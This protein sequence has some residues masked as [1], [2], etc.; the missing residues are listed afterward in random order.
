MEVQGVSSFSSRMAEIRASFGAP[1]GGAAGVAELG[2]G[3][4]NG[5][6]DVAFDAFGAAYQEALLQKASGAYAPAAGRSASVGGAGNWSWAN[7][8]GTYGDVPGAGRI[9]G[10]GGLEVP[11]ALA[12]YGNGH[13]PYEAL[14]PIG[15]GGHRLYQPAAESFVAMRAAAAQDGV[16]LT[17]TDSYRTYDQQVE[18]AQ[19]KGLYENGGLAA[20]PGTSPHGWGMAV[21][22]NVNDPSTYQWLRTHGAEYGWV[23]TS[24]R[25]PW[26]WEYRPNEA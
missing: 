22:A 3:A 16:G 9:G 23:Q 26:H 19:R 11:A 4:L 21:D 12:A 24:S 20:V 15:Q 14:T 13:I 18:L 8:I 5:P 7:G 6:T 1:A 2:G 10:Y 25:E 17:I